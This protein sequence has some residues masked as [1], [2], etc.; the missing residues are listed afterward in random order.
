MGS[1]ILF[2]RDLG[3]HNSSFKFLIAISK[4][5]TEIIKLSSPALIISGLLPIIADKV[6]LFS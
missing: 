1:Q 6:N 5:N 3:D 2:F 4:L